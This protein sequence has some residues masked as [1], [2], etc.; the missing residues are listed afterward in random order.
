MVIFADESMV[1]NGYLQLTG[2]WDQHK[3]DTLT[4]GQLGKSAL[5]RKRLT[6][7]DGSQITRNNDGHHCWAWV[8]AVRQP[9]AG[10]G[11]VN[12]WEWPPWASSGYYQQTKKHNDQNFSPFLLRAHNEGLWI[13]FNTDLS[14]IQYWRSC[15]PSCSTGECAVPGLN[16]MLFSLVYQLCIAL[17]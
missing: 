5:P 6:A 1:W 8:L 4:W 13:S 7:G 2:E 12:D 14:V 10:W 17:W 3:C 16:T 9:R 15:T 11:V